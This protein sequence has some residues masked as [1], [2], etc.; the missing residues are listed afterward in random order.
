M[1]FSIF[2]IIYTHDDNDLN[3]VVGIWIPVQ[4]YIEREFTENKGTQAFAVF[5]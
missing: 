3:I 2:L 1:V 5:N 4:L